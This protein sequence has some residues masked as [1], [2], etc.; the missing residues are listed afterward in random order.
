VPANPYRGYGFQKKSFPNAY[1]CTSNFAVSLREVE[2]M[3]AYRGVELKLRDYPSLVRYVWRFLCG[4]AKTE[5]AQAGRQM[6][7]GR[8]VFKDQR[9]AAL[10]LARRRPTAYGH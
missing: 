2:L 3:M 9:R 10:F 8:S 7:P 4:Q 6:V 5:A 1:G